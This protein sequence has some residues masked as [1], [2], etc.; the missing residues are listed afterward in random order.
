MPFLLDGH[1]ESNLKGVHVDL[2]RVVRDCAANM[3]GAMTFGVTEGLRT[4]AQQKIDIS[5]GKSQT[6]RSRHLDGHA[7]DLVTLMSGKVSW[8]WPGFYALADQVRAAGIR[9]GIPLI[10]GCVWDREMASWTQPAMLEAADYI[11]RGG[12]FQDGPHVELPWRA[13]PS[14]GKPA[15]PLT[16]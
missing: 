7:V 9:C 14:G 8:A 11:K 16:S 6:M 5:A 13:Y 15:A 2:V 3:T 12:H 10:W 4:I 1:S